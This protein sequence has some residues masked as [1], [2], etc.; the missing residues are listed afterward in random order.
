MVTGRM[1]DPEFKT[2]PTSDLELWQDANV[3]KHEVFNNIEDLIGN[4]KKNGLRVPLLVKPKNGRYLVFSG[5][6]RL[7]ACRAAK[8]EKIP[9]FVFAGIDLTDARVLSLSENLYRQ[10]MTKEDKAT[11]A[12]NLFQKFKNITR[13]AA[14]LGVKENTVK[15][16]FAYDDIPD[17]LKKFARNNM[18]LTTKQ[19][20]D[21]YVKFSATDKAV[22]IAAKL[23]R[24]K[25]RNKQRKMHASIRQSAPSDDIPTIERRAEK[26]LRM[27]T[28]KIRLPDNDYKTIEKIAYSRR[29]DEED[30]LVEIVE[31]WISEYNEGRHV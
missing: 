28:Y 17:D 22:S 29:I 1:K 20:E 3:R 26:M 15:K 19:V 5:Q 30:L 18:G 9:C 6:R 16:Y 25:S 24:I 13:V 31:N 2:I 27:K 12:K 10:S 4:V 11:A 8:L 23:S 21:I 14:A 7:I